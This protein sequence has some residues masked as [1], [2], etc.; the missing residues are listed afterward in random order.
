[1][2][3][4]AGRAAVAWRWWSV[5]GVNYLGVGVLTVIR[6]RKTMHQSSAVPF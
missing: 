3:F 4:A 1:M 2:T 6:V 5:E